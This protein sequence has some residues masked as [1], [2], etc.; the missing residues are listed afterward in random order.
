M[1]SIHRNHLSLPIETEKT[2]E[3]LQLS[4]ILY[5]CTKTA[6]GNCASRLAAAFSFYIHTFE[7]PEISHPATPFF[8]FC[9][10]AQ[11]TARKT[12]RSAKVCCYLYYITKKRFVNTFC[13]HCRRKDAR[14]CRK[15]YDFMKKARLAL[16]FP[17]GYGMI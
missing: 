6:P 9:I 11:S 16:L 15:V 2:P 12:V 1:S 10:H 13:T 4:A 7:T 14:C 8:H 5:L 17:A 3:W